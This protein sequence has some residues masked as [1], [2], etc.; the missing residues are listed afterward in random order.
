MIDCLR[1]HEELVR[2]L[3]W[4]KKD[5]YDWPIE[6]YAGKPIKSFYRL[7]CINLKKLFQAVY[8]WWRRRRGYGKFESMFFPIIKKVDYQQAA[9]DIIQIQDLPTQPGTTFY[10][11]YKYSKDP[12]QKPHNPETRPP[13]T[14]DTSNY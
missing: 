3:P 12:D 6:T 8:W 5:Y 1:K 4:W 2:N 9:K 13:L 11:D 7:V 10:M 14:W